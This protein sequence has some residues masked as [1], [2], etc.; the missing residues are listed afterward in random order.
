[1]WKLLNRIAL[2]IGL[3]AVHLVKPGVGAVDA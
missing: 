3:G 1:M 2:F